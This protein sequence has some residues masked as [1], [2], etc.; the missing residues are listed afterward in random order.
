[1][2]LHSFGVL[3]ACYLSLLVKAA[4]YDGPDYHSLPLDTIF[5]G[6]WESN[7]RAPQNKSYI[8]PVRIFNYEGAT[9]G[10]ERVL[11]DAEV[12]VDGGLTWGIAPGG[13]VTFEFAENIGGRVCFEV[14]DVQND[15]YL[16]LSYSESP[17][18]AG[19]ECDGSDESA[20]DLPLRY[21]I[22][23]PG[24]NCVGGSYIRGAFKYL[25]IFMPEY[26]VPTEG[27]YWHDGH[28]PPKRVPAKQ[29]WYEALAQKIFGRE[30]SVTYDKSK[31]PRVTISA[32][33]VNC[34]SFPSNPNGRAYTGYFDSSS[35]M[36]NR[37]WYA[38]AWT[39]QLS[40]ID[41]KEGG[42]LI[43]F[44]RNFDHNSSPLGSWYANFTV[45]NG[46]T[47]TT[48]GAKRD[49]MVWPGDMTIAVP[50]IAVSTYDMLAV[51]NALNV[52]YDHQYHDGSMPYAGP[53]MGNFGE[54]SDTYH[55][56][57]LIGTYIY[58]LYSGDLEWLEAR[59]AAYKAAL[60]V[61][62]AKVDETGLLHVSST[63]DWNRF[64]LTGHNIEASALLYEAVG[65]TLK[66][67][68]WLT[69]KNQEEIDHWHNTRA[70]MF[71]G[72]NDILYCPQDGM[73]ADNLGRR[74]CHGNEKVLPQD[75]NGWA[76][77]SGVFPSEDIA[78]TVS[79]NL[80]KRWN[81]YGAPAVEFPNVMSP[82][83]S[84]F[85]LLGHS[86]AGN[87][88]AAV[89]LIELMW[90]YML[91]GPGM[92]NSTLIEGYRVDGYVHYP[93][94]W[95][96][97]R[98]S[99]AHGWAAGPTTALMQGILGIKLQSPLG[100]TWT[101]EPQLSKW[102]SYAR[103][104]FATKLG[105]FEV[106]ISLMRSLSTNRKIEALNVNVPK[107]TSGSIKWGGQERVHT[108]TMGSNFSYFRYLDVR[109]QAEE[110]WHP[111]NEGD[112]RDFVSD[113]TFVKPVSEERPEGI[114]DWVALEQNYALADQRF[115]TNNANPKKPA[116]G[117]KLEM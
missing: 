40:T 80:R 16:V 37:V 64:G 67:A 43:Q 85:E 19:R 15:P 94:Y 13:L 14:E 23:K 58:V 7:I 22:N 53:P 57:S 63:S 36:L 55:L 52:I 26:D 39:L 31:E 86:A 11:E 65:N 101:I 35:S 48:D 99:H 88:D 44:N 10:A 104:G 79:E 21:A 113:D 72:I 96:V 66:L 9:F 115:S 98:N 42:S 75:G 2:H 50:G 17:F 106:D 24:L 78:L 95:Q 60:E 103:G 97:A 87:P 41:P 82:F 117:V 8:T 84:S 90:G 28:I 91:D 51:R 76:L 74:G 110:G 56:H 68:D 33:W 71:K 30:L 38:G 62:I 1:M 20:R 105:K 61:S 6:P 116:A 5:P 81:K 70:R 77:I 12:V 59:W 29:T 100:K 18:F 83:S 112:E 92:T 107:N 45:G 109:T 4:E 102:L 27:G 3:G 32:V 54:F 69:T 34:T 49:R 89:E 47:I 108:E 46:T 114:V 93:A 73:Y 111:W 25:T